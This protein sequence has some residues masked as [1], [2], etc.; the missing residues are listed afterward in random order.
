V[1]SAGPTG[2][3]G[4]GKGDQLIGHGG[5][6]IIDGGPGRDILWGGAGSDLLRVRDGA[7]DVVICGTGADRVEADADAGDVIAQDCERV[8][9]R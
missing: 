6:D 8:V 7:N 1:V 2:C 3:R 9:R 5:P 4:L